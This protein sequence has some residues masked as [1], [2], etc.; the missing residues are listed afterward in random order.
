MDK[1]KKKKKNIKFGGNLIWMTSKK[2]K[3]WR[4]ANLA[5]FHQIR[6]IY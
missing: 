6:Q 1:K 5:D 4:D 2:R 3:F